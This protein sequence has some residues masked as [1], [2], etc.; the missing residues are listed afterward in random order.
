[1]NI[2]DQVCLWVAHRMKASYSPFR[3]IID[4]ELDRKEVEQPQPRRMTK[5]TCGKL[6]TADTTAVKKVLWP[7]ELV[8]TPDCQPATYESLSCMAFV[9]GYI[10]IMDLQTVTI[11]NKM[12][13]HLQE[14]MEDGEIFGWSV[15]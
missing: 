13:I 7:H 2:E 1:M 9:N 3:A 11:R 12:T 5:L 10:S 15:V 4:D 14:I 6:R 8:F